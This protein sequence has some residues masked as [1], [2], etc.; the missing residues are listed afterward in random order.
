[1]LVWFRALPAN[2]INSLDALH[3]Q[4]LNKWEKKNNPLQILSEYESVRRGPNEN[5]QDYYTRFNNIYNA[6]LVNLRPLPDLALIKFHD[7]FHKNMAYQLR[8]RNTPTLEEM[9]SVVVSLQS[10]LLAK[11]TRV[12][13]E[14][15]GT[16]N[17][18]ASS[19]DIKIDS[20]AK[21]MEKLMHRIGNMERKPQWDNQQ[22]PLVRN[23][24]LKKKPKPKYW[25]NGSDQNIRPHFQEN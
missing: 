3:Q 17:D 12:R 16:S 2:S 24:N 10:N 7:G 15:R 14:R 22:A 21:G 6:I 8:E 20:L 4:F 19:S 23:P 5:V 25:E 1:M 13:N 18:E 9:K 11:R